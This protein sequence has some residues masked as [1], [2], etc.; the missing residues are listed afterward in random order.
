MSWGTERDNQKQNVV[1]ITKPV[2]DVSFGD[3]LCK[4]HEQIVKAYTINWQLFIWTPNLVLKNT[5][6]HHSVSNPRLLKKHLS[7]QLHYLL[8]HVEHY[9]MIPTNNTLHTPVSLISI[10]SDTC[11]T[12]I[13][14]LNLIIRNTFSVNYSLESFV[15][16]DFTPYS[17]LK[18]QRLGGTS[19]SLQGQS[20]GQAGTQSEAG[21]CLA[22]TQEKKANY[23]FLG[24]CQSITQSSC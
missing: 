14:L 6:V 16:S 17:S 12:R 3:E 1:S 22:S 11:L 9:S 21:I 4:K 15:C 2:L 13:I 24:L 8:I 10:M 19:H 20:V 7:H 18:Q 23:L 5:K